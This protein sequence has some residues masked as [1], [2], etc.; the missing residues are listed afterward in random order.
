MNIQAT[1]S[2]IVEDFEGL[3]EWGHWQRHVRPA[4]IVHAARSRSFGA[5][6]LT[7]TGPT[8]HG[9]QKNTQTVAVRSESADVNSMSELR[10]EDEDQTVSNSQGNIKALD[11]LFSR[12]RRTLFLVAYR[13]LGDHNQA[14]DALQRCLQ[15]A[16][17]NV[18]QFENEGA[19]RSWLVR[20]LIDE[21]LLILH[22]REWAARTF[23]TDRGWGYPIDH[24]FPREPLF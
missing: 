24:E 14:G 17:Y 1:L 18:P 3:R 10:S 22:G 5:I 11:V 2:D 13:V 8:T 12:Y 7:G 4:T 16:S 19:F 20:V 23:R 15:S 21:A 6:T 9:G